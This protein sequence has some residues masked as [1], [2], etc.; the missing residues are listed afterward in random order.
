MTQEITKVTVTDFMGIGGTIELFPSGALQLIAGPNGSGKS[1]LM[2]AIEE[3]FDPE[4]TRLIPK[5]IHHGAKEARVEIT[6]TTARLVRV[7]P[8]DGPGTLSAYALDGAKYPS[9]KEFVVAATGGALFDPDDFVLL[10]DK[11]QREQ[12]LARVALPFDLD[13]IT[14]KRKGFF[15]ARTEATREVK[16]LDAYLASYPAAD[17]SVPTEEVS[18]AALLDE[19]NEAT[20]RNRGIEVANAELDRQNARMRA[21]DS[22]ILSLNAERT[23][24]EE[25]A[26][27]AAKGADGQPVDTAAITARL[28]EVEETNAAVRSQRARAEVAAQL[29]EQM[30]AEAALTASIDAIDKQKAAGLAAAAFPIEGLGIDDSGIV[31][32]G[33]P[34]KQVNSALQ[35]TIAFDLATSGNPDLKV[36][37]MKHGD[38]L[39][40]ER[41]EGIRK[42]ADERG[43]LVFMERDREESRE[44]GFLV[45]GTTAA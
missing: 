39:D 41:L 29:D 42:L 22:E 28:G 8:K 36:V 12:L 5:P 13:E 23:R 32:D 11:K 18:A 16:R 34:F 26:A 3:V 15:D 10:D 33:I 7:Y 38:R 19:H 45:N 14:A 9:G 40:T 31:F 1:S 2:H 25:A 43:Y 44:V 30:E 37:V 24:A 17:P 6:T 4:G 27:I 35:D 21:I 20:Q